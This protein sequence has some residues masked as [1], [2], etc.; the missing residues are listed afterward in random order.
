MRG[1][2]KTVFAVLTAAAAATGTFFGISALEKSRS[3]QKPRAV[4][5]AMTDDAGEAFGQAAG[6]FCVELPFA[7]EKQRLHLCRLSLRG[8]GWVQML[9]NGLD[10]EADAQAEKEFGQEESAPASGRAT[11]PKGESGKTTETTETKNKSPKNRTNSS[12]NETNRPSDTPKNETE[13][14]DGDVTYV[15]VFPAGSK[16]DVTFVAVD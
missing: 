2:G 4:F 9:W 8:I 12:K 16:E 10:G 13:Q 6:N 7:G 14:S 3:E 11:E 15:R 5:P 1:A